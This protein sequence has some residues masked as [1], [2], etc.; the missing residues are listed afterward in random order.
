RVLEASTAN[1]I[2]LVQGALCTPPLDGRIVPGIARALLLEG[3]AARGTPV[4]ERVLHRDELRRAQCVWITNAV[5]GARVARLDGSPAAEA[6]PASW[7]AR[8]DE[9]WAA[10]I[11]RV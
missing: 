9:I 8:L 2:A 5:H 3:L 6:A 10:A 11:G 7:T 1:V 4:V